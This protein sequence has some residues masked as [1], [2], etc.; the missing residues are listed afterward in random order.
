MQLNNFIQY[1]PNDEKRI[2]SIQYF[3][4]DNGVDFYDSFEEFKLK[5]KIGFDKQGIIRTVSED[6]SAI[7][8]LDL[9]I[10][11][12]SSLPTD[13]NIDGR[14]IYKNGAIMQ[15]EPSLEESVFLASQQK[16]L[17]LEEAT[18]A[19]APLQDA[20][21]LGIATGEER[22]PLIKWKEYRVLLNRVDTSLAPDIDWPEKPE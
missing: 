17:L 7:Y 20:V 6:I 12:V 18:A 10:V 16:K 14:W 1:T 8:P 2:Q 9:S 21:D 3:I 5:Y 19:I 15:Y 4:S 13:F 11:D 22:E